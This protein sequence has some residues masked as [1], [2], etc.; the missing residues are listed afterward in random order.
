M[1]ARRRL[2]G[3]LGC[4]VVVDHDHGLA[5]LMAALLDVDVVVV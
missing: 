3:L 1:I 4:F 2:L 5:A